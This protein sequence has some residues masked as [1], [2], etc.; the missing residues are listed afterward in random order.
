MCDLAP[1][2]LYNMQDLHHFGLSEQILLHNVQ[3]LR[4][5]L[6]YDVKGDA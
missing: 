4:G 3:D 5:R 1:T 2:L 6:Y